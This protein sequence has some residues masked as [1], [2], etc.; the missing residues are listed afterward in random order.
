MFPPTIQSTSHPELANNNETSLI[1][2]C[3]S[4]HPSLSLDSCFGAPTN[5]LINID[6]ENYLV[7][8]AK[9][10]H[11]DGVSPSLLL[12]SLNYSEVALPL[13]LAL[14]S[15]HGSSLCATHEELSAD[16]DIV[17]QESFV[18]S[19]PRGYPKPSIALTD[20]CSDLLGSTRHHHHHQYIHQHHD[21]PS[22]HTLLEDGNLPL[23]MLHGSTMQST[24]LD[25]FGHLNI[26]HHNHNGEFVRPFLHGE[27]GHSSLSELDNPEEDL[28]VTWTVPLLRS[29]M[30]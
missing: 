13:P 16:H 21:P 11:V 15:S 24:S 9:Q 25:A 22:P 6:Q 30:Y 17:A 1:I 27:G 7:N 18:N 20:C 10:A 2:P 28:K 5:P 19:S 8:H 4:D 14:S 26:S 12:T 3:P 29:V 23:N